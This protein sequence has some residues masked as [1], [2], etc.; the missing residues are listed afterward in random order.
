MESI[1]HPTHFDPQLALPLIPFDQRHC[2]LA[3]KLKEAGLTW[4]RH[5]EC[6]VRGPVGCIEGPYP[7][8]KRFYFTLNLD[9]FLYLLAPWRKSSK[10]GFGFPHG[11]RP[12]NR[13][14]GSQG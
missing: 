11:V 4:R 8:P 14:K 2:Q 3:L 1:L 12:V 7:F 6:F 5:E 10:N 9:H 13:E